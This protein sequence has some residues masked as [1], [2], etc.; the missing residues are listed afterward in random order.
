MQLLSIPFSLLCSSFLLFA[1]TA[2][3]VSST[4]LT[5]DTFDA[6]VAKGLS[7]IEHFSPWCGHCK[8]FK[9]MWE[10]LVAETQT[11][12]PEVK[13]ATINCVDYGGMSARYVLLSVNYITL[14]RP[15]RKK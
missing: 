13:T 1:T 10:Q 4:E 8:H 11:E 14:H 3:P 7:F 6:A 9:P 12:I 2:V 5:P 15:L